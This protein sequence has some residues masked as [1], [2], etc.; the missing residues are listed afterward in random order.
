MTSS[1]STSGKIATLVSNFQTSFAVES[2]SENLSWKCCYNSWMIPQENTT[3]NWMVAS[4]TNIYL[5]SKWVT[6]FTFTC[7]KN[8]SSLHLALRWVYKS[9]IRFSSP[10]SFKLR[11]FTRL[12]MSVTKANFQTHSSWESSGYG[13]PSPSRNSQS[14]SFN[15]KTLV[16]TSPQLIHPT[17]L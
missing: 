7:F 2:K 10:C 9:H 11:L 17:A 8:R 5:F 13:F 4:A 15:S 1:C 12:V 6:L 14:F 16:S 3:G